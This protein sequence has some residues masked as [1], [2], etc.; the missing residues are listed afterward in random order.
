MKRIVISALLAAGFCGPA[1]ADT[2]APGHKLVLLEAVADFSLGV[3]KQW[4]ASADP[5]AAM[6]APEVPNAFAIP[7]RDARRSVDT[8]VSEGASSLKEADAE[9]LASCEAIRPK[10]LL[11][12]VIVAHVS[13][14]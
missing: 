2:V 12:C 5:Y 14:N 13:P 6:A 11:P 9:A 7:V 3:V 1:F 8:G 10:E 4:A